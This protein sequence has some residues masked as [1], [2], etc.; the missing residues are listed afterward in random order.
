[1]P[2]IK[3]LLAC[4]GSASVALLATVLFLSPVQATQEQITFM[5]TLE[6]WKYPGSAMPRGGQMSDGGNPEIQDLTCR[7]VLT[8]PDSFEDVV[9]FYAKKTGEVPAKA[10]NAQAVVTQDDSKDRPIKVRIISVHKA[11][12]SNTL[13]ISRAVEGEK[14]TRIVAWV[15]L[16]AA[17]A[18]NERRVWLLQARLT[19][20]G[21]SDKIS[22]NQ[23]RI[24]DRSASGGQ[25]GFRG[26]RL[27][28]QAKVDSPAHGGTVD[29]G[30]RR[31]HRTEKSSPW[32]NREIQFRLAEPQAIEQGRLADAE[33]RLD[34]M[35]HEE[36]NRTRARLLLVQALRQQGRIT[37]AEEILQRTI[38]VGLPVEEARREYA[39]LSAYSDFPRAEKSLRRLLEAHP[40]DEEIRQAL[41]AGALPVG[42]QVKVLRKPR[43]RGRVE[44]VAVGYRNPCYPNAGPDQL[45]SQGGTAPASG[46]SIRLRLRMSGLAL[47]SSSAACEGIESRLTTPMAWP[48]GFSRPTFIWAIFTP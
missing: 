8:T 41:K 33:A 48:P 17:L 43:D 18:L 23:R 36:P 14:E 44:P 35:V 24:H 27:I 31:G 5:Q 39:L 32:I 28:D 45:A 4:A 6:E 3:T 42:W 37:E 29:P 21:T 38:E 34:L 30:C 20:H 15:S 26:R 47:T 19:D 13:V 1:M 46:R 11:D 10:P 2:T 7:A 9:A 40:D 22:S 12:R 16:P 25:D